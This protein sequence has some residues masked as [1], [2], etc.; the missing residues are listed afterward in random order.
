[1]KNLILVFAAAVIISLTACGQN[2]K[3][4]PEKVKAAFETKFPGA[5]DVKWDKENS[6]EW[7]AEFISGGIKMSANYASDGAW[8]ETESVIP[9]SQL[10]A[11]V[12]TAVSKKFPNKTV[13]EADKI[14][15]A[16]KGSLFEVVI[17]TGTKKKE[18]VFDENGVI[19]K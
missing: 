10:P 1:M 3:N 17:N 7:E 18:I 14:E 9:A 16:G 12:A 19:Q 13:M 15:R 4:V 6:K 5:Q 8:L 11:E 2:A